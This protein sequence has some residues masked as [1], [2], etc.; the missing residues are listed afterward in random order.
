MDRKYPQVICRACT[1]RVI[2]FAT[3]STIARIT[4]AFSRKCCCGAASSSSA[5]L[6]YSV[7]CCG[8]T[9]EAIRFNFNSRDELQLRF[10]V[11]L[12]NIGSIGFGGDQGLV[13]ETSR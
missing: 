5:R 4:P 2:N 11:E 3:A 6:R 1:S 12:A 9:V 8:L 13:A 7:Q 10:S